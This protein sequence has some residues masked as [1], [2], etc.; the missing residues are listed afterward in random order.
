M[1]SGNLPRRPGR[2]QN[3]PAR[4]HMLGVLNVQARPQA[5]GDGQVGRT[6]VEGIDPFNLGDGL[7]L[8]DRLDMLDLNDEGNLLV[9]PLIVI[10]AV[11]A[12]PIGPE[13]PIA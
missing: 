2:L 9:G 11:E 6:D 10:G 13:T 7:D 3:P 4:R 8:M 5:H 12:G 1:D